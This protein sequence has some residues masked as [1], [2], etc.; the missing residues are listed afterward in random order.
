MGKRNSLS[1]PGYFDRIRDVCE[2]VVAGATAAGIPDEELFRLELACDEACTNVIEHAYGGEGNGELTVT[3]EVVGDQFV[4]IL[5][6]RGQAFDPD[7][8]VKPD[9]PQ[10]ADDSEKL[11]V[12]GLGLHIIRQVMDEI[13]FNFSPGHN[14]LLMRKNIPGA[15]S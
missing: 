11:R 9:I 13:E 14:M 2:F 15:G 8:V 12:G 7:A 5:A 10:T 3:Y 4:I 6:D 1:I